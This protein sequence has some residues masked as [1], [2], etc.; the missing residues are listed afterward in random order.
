MITAAL[1]QTHPDRF[2]AALPMCGVLSGGVATWITALDSEFAFKTL[3]A[4][5]T[6][7]E[8]VNI[9]N[10]LAKSRC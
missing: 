6:G 5:G 4:P 2:D 8:V 3:L 7:L 10:L 1:I 9:S